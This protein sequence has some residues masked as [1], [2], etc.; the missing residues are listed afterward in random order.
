MGKWRYTPFI[1]TIGNRWSCQLHVPEERP[2]VSM[3]ASCPGRVPYRVHVSFTSRKSAPPCPCQLHVP[4]ECPVVSMFASRPGRVP[5]SVHISFTSQNS[6]PSC[7]C[8]LHVP[9]KCPYQLHV[10]EGCPVVS[11]GPPQLVLTFWRT[12]KSIASAGFQTPDRPARSLVTIPTELPRQVIG[13]TEQT[14]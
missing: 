14:V 13:T 7:P 5:C 6:V 11:S 8:Q 2:V 10:P 12:E 1:L 4:K 3:S 9:E